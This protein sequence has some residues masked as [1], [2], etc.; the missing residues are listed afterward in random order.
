MMMRLNEPIILYN[1]QNKDCKKNKITIQIKIFSAPFLSDIFQ[2]SVILNHLFIVFYKSASYYT[3]KFFP[4]YFSKS[5]F[6]LYKKNDASFVLLE[7]I[8]P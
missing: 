8:Y 7:Y 1:R 3:D 4:I 2:D 6:L 5:T